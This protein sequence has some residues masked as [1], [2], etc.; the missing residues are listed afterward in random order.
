MGK[1]QKTV[2]DYVGNLNLSNVITE[3]K[4]LQQTAKGKGADIFNVNQQIKNLEELEK[5]IQQTISGGYKSSKDIAGLENLFQKFSDSAEKI[6]TSIKNV[7][8]DALEK[9]VKTANE[10]LKKAEKKLKQIEQ[11]VNKVSTVSTKYSGLLISAAKEGKDLQK[12]QKTISAD[13]ESQVKS[14]KES[15][16]QTQNEINK[17]KE[18]EKLLKNK[19]TTMP[20]VLRTGST[21]ASSS[22][23]T[24]DQKGE[25]IVDPQK[26]KDIKG[27]YSQV[28]S[29]SLKKGLVDTEIKKKLTSA[30][31]EKLG[32]SVKNETTLDTAIQKSR[33]S[34]E[35][36]SESLANIKTQLAEL[37]ELLK[38]DK[39]EL[40]SADKEYEKFTQ[41]LAEVK[42][43]LQNVSEA[44]N[45]VTKKVQNLEQAQQNLANGPT[46]P[47][48]FE[49][50]DE[51]N[52]EME[53]FLTLNKDLQETTEESNEK[54]QEITTTIKQY[55]SAGMA[56]R[57]AWEQLKQTFSDVREIDKSFAE[58]AM[59]TDYS[60]EEMWSS[61]DQYAQMA[62]NLGQSTNDVIKASGLFYQQG[63]DTAE[64]LELTESTMRLAT[65]AGQD[66][67]EAT[68]EMTA[69]LR[70]FHMEMDQ[71]EHIADVYSELAAKAAADVEGIAY[72]MSK[73][74]SIANSAGMSFE[75]TSAF[76]T[77]MI[78]TTQE[79]P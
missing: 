6:R 58:I 48:A 51:S 41:Y 8:T 40:E 24:A 52:S 1:N 49:S 55:V 39:K 31:K 9:G 64:S 66:F 33:S 45:E 22:F 35:K 78:E 61:Y 21:A 16:A 29:E 46:V 76:L 23:K 69:A 42:E 3:L 19:A 63:L 30:F 17:L 4:K 74:A 7:E 77:Q 27:V 72:A 37:N 36:T 15:L 50:L 75:N 20:S 43:K 68:S 34:Y 38:I 26:L 18:Q 71:G 57:E 44:S 28:L 53:N 14:K 54:F 25:S 56:L 79:A 47:E 12:I 59:V 60:V 70:G 73:T 11:S 32:V 5:K 2:F 65:L 67:E 62:N 10:E 13:L